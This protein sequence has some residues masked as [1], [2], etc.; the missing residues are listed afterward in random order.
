MY[1]GGS[2]N[3]SNPLAMELS[4]RPKGGSTNLLTGSENRT[5][6]LIGAGA[7]GATLVIVGVWLFRKNRTEEAEDEDE[8]EDLEAVS[9]DL[10]DDRDALMDAIIALDDLYKAGELPE[11]A[12][13][14]RRS[15]LKEKLDRMVGKDHDPGAEAGQTLWVEKCS[16][17]GF[18][19]SMRVNLWLCWVSNGAGKTTFLRILASLSRPSR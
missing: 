2:F 15:Q 9:S 7:L 13:Q 4:G 8:E 6:L 5:N 18:S 14:Q 10:P 3:A 11:E 17:H 1:S 16:T 19:M 12:Y